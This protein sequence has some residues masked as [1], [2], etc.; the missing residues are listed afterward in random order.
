MSNLTHNVKTITRNSVNIPLETAAVATDV[1]ADASTL[2]LGTVGGA[3]P[4]TYGVGRAIKKL[5]I[6]VFN[7]DITDAEAEAL[8]TELTLSLL[9]QRAE[10]NALHLG[11]WAGKELRD[12]P[13]DRA[14]KIADLKSEIARIEAEA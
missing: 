9:A 11:Q 8:S 5:S 10:A 13:A 12:S 6:G 7:P 14:N 3:L 1:I 2:V 4:F